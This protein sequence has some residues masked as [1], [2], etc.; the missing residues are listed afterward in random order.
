MIFKISFLG[1]RHLQI[2]NCQIM[3]KLD[4]HSLSGCKINLEM[5]GRITNEN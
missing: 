1:K 3:D 4:P 2:E 5:N